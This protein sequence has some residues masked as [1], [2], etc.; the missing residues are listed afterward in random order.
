MPARGTLLLAVILASG[1]AGGCERREVT[2]ID[3]SYGANCG[4]PSGNV[5]GAVAR[6]C[7]GTSGCQ[8]LVDVTQL[9]DPVVG[10]A[11]DFRVVWRCATEE[12]IS[13]ALA[14]PEAGRGT[15]VPLQC[16]VEAPRRVDVLAAGSDVTPVSG[17]TDAI[18]QRCAG[19]TSC[20]IGWNDLATMRRWT[21]GTTAVR[22]HWRCE[23][24]MTKRESIVSAADTARLS[25][26]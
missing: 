17:L 19:R 9:G 18:I 3:A 5:T 16:S 25:C 12:T 15:V 20:D 21:P 23:G 24:E 14:P 6:A 11:K 8:F 7:D 26:E 13:T 22:V 10:C 4:A 1:A 2:V